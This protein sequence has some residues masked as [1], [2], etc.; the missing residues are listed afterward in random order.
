MNSVYI[1]TKVYS[2]QDSLTRLNNIKNK[3]IWIIC[4]GFL[5]KGGQLNYLLKFV[6]DSNEVS[7][8]DEVV[9]EPPIEVIGKG[10]SLI[11]N[12]NPDI[13]IGYGGGSAIDTAKGIIY[14]SKEANIIKDVTFIAIPTTS[15]TGSEVTSATVI[16]DREMKI[17]HAIFDDS[18]LPDEAILD[19]NLTLSVPPNITANTGMDVLTH[20]IE[21]YV[22]KNSN[23]YSDALAEKSVELVVS[24]LVKAYKCG[25]D[26]EARSKMHEASN[27]AGMS[28]N[29]AGLGIT[30]SLAHQ[31]GSQF[32]IPHGLATALFLNSVI[33]Y[34]SKKE[35]CLK[36]YAK[37]AR[38]SGMVTKADNDEFAVKVLEEYIETIMNMMNMPTNLRKCNVNL[39]DLTNLK[40]T[41]IENALNDGCTE[42]NPIK[43]SKDDLG[44]LI[45]KI[46]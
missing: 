38:K 43:C 40:D 37:L 19:A 27:L 25:D 14:F 39:N 4:D 16:T 10:I 18:V 33:K 22:S 28:F 34:N 15:G 23:V 1:K 26:L 17:K 13:L 44:K 21:A 46:Y 5:V 35:E 24:S 29:I 36:K 9:P 12:I 6:D 7:I 20:A 45:D 42:S 32:H 2:G 30:H 11:K 3:K 41:M 8:F 31:I